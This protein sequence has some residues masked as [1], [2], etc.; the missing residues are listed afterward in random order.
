VSLSD[1]APSVEELRKAH[2]EY[3]RTVPNNYA[4]TIQRVAAAL[5]RR[6]SDELAVAV[7]E[8]LQDLNRQY[9]RFRPEEAATLVERLKP[10]LRQELDTFLKFRDRSIT[11]LAKIDEAE[12]L[13]LFGLFRTE[14]GPVGAGKAL[15]VLAPNFFPLWDNA[16]AEGY[17]VA[18]ETGYFQFINIVK[19]QVLNLT[20]EVAPEVTALKA[21]DEYNYLYASASRKAAS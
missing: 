8:W 20:E 5:S 14:C 15:H 18:T 13:R 12:A 11:T 3:K 21:L 19:Q 9:Y 17:G 10:I 16:I 7:A 4:I 2:E 1:A 6:N